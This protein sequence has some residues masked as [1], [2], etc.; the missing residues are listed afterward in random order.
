MI[1]ADAIKPANI[2]DMVG[3]SHIIGEGTLL[4]AFIDKGEFDSLCFYGQPGTGKTTLAKLI[5]RQ[6]NYRFYKFHAATTS[7]A[8]IKKLL[9]EPSVSIETV[10]L[11]I[12]EIHQFNKVQQGF[13][14]DFLDNKRGKI[15]TTSTENPYYSLIPALRSR[16]YLFKFDLLDEAALL[17]LYYR[18]KKYWINRNK[19]IKEINI[20]EGELKNCINMSNG[21]G[22]KFLNIIEAAFLTG[23]LRED[24]LFVTADSISNFVT[25]ITYSEDEYYDLLSAMI[26]S[27]RGS[28]P[29][30]AL[31]WAFKLLKSGISPEVIL[32]RLLISASEDI[33][34]AYPD[35]LSFVSSAYNAF[36]KVGLP[37]GNI[38]ISHIITF[39]ASC[40]K[41]NKSYVAYNNVKAYLEKHNPYPPENIRHATKTYKYPFDYGAFVIQNYMDN[42]ETFYKPSKNGFEMKIAERLKKL[43]GTLKSYE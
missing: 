26:K 13:L 11:V 8:D 22:R 24:K 40:P 32:R 31:V 33:G 37:E 18:A 4:R 27:I 43:W 23:E 16:S 14:L 42:C 12:D 2:R 10:L 29:D 3:Q 17:E 1:I 39:L 5:S 7:I 30:A 19:N 21:D 28:D 41:S 6:L 36:E 34:N 35:A 9:N 20:K 38:I 15:I 25:T